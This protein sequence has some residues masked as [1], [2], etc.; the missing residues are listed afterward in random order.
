MTDFSLEQHGIDVE[1]VIRN[2][3]PAALYEAALRNERGTAISGSGALVA[4]SGEKT[5]RS[6]TDKRIVED[7]DTSD[8]IWWGPINIKLEERVFNINRE[9]AIDYL[10]T[11]E[12]LYCVDGYAGWDPKHQHQGPRRSAPARI[13]RSSCTTC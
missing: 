10:N 8:D 1:H 5:G 7:P 3:S 9:R 6:P 12:F 2:V 11:R 4:L 13:T